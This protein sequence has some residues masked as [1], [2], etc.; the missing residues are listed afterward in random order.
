MFL[1]LLLIFS[2]VFITAILPVFSK[3]PVVVKIDSFNVR[4]DELLFFI[5][6]KRAE[7]ASYFNRQYNLEFGK[8]FWKTK[9][10]GTT[11]LEYAKN[12]AANE[13]A[14]IKVIQSLAVKYGLTDD[15]SFESIAEDFGATGGIIK[16]E[17]NG[18]VF[19]Q[20]FNRFYDYYISNLEI[21]VKYKVIEN[22]VEFTEDDLLALYKETKQNYVYPSIEGEE[23]SKELKPFEEVKDTVLN[24]YCNRAFERIVS[25][26]A[27][28]YRVKPRLL[29]WLTIDLN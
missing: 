24:L 23:E 20:E 7:T 25:E 27:N 19:T 11:P 26:T 6:K 13:L 3:N 17:T 28:G 9:V 18:E 1:C 12:S 16:D 2:V 4:K 8:D 21:A 22:E 29:F 15:V 10:D 14:R 5:Q